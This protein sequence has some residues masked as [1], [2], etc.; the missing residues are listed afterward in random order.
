MEE[1]KKKSLIIIYEIAMAL[2][3][4]IVVLML[5]IDL[6]CNLPQSISSTFNIVDN[7]I[8]V[9]FAIDYFVRFFF[10]E[11][12]KIFFKNNIIDL[13]SIVPFN[14][15]FQATRLLRLS[16][17][18]RL[19]KFIKL[20]KAFRSVAL[21]LKFKKHID[22][23][24]KTNNFHYVI[25]ITLITLLVGTLGIHFTEGIT[26]GNAL[27]WSFVTITTVGY[28]DISPITPIGRIIASILMLVGI[29]FLSMLTGTIST[30]FLSKNSST[31]YKCQTIE[32]IKAKLD[33]FDELST[34]D[35]NDIYKVLKALKE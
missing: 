18:I 30:F 20:L 11:N 12:K 19:T 9:I 32:D 5:T 17:L 16:K 31:G 6:S 10:A 25:L 4:L 28:G 1:P 15:A 13:I 8:L 29:G 34:E 26:F 2:L 7:S 23:F 35:I 24:I 22:R 33:N 27:W 21:L 3:A 14:Y